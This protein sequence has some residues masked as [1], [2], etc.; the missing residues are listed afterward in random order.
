MH[1]QIMIR[2]INT[3]CELWKIMAQAQFLKWTRKDLETGK[4]FDVLF[5]MA[6]RPSVLG[7]WELV[8]PDNCLATVLSM[9]G[10][11]EKKR[12]EHKNMKMKVLRKMCGVK[13]IPEKYWVEAGEIGNSITIAD[14]LRGLSSLEINGVIIY[15]IGIKKDEFGEM[16]DP[17]T[18]KTYYQELL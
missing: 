15:P 10:F 4:D 6:L 2:G 14:S 9:L 1:L 3:Q 13:K 16:L 5:Q 18:G 11:H 7:T 12:G 8:F 17:N